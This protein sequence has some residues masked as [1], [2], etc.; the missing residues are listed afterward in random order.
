MKFSPIIYWTHE[1]GEQN[2]AAGR[3]ANRSTS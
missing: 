3:G 1:Q 2:I